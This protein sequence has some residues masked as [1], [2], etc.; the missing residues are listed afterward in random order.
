MMSIDLGNNTPSLLLK[1][2]VLKSEVLPELG[3]IEHFL[4][5]FLI[6]VSSITYF[7]R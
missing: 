4:N 5:D 7:I 6:S 2:Y 1:T 3:P